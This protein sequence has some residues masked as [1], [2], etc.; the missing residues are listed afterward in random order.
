M[1]KVKCFSIAMLLF[2]LISACSAPQLSTPPLPLPTSTS[3]PTETA[4]PRPTYTNTPVPTPTMIPTNTP[5]GQI[6]RDDFSIGIQ[7]DWIWQNENPVRWSIT[8]E[9]WL[10]ILGEDASLLVDDFQNNLLCRNAPGGDYQISV[11]LFA[12]PIEDF[13]QATLYLYQDGD[14][15]I[16]INRGYCSICPTGGNGVFMEYKLAGA[17]GVYRVRTQANDIFL[18]LVVKGQTIIG[19]YAFETEEWQ[20]FGKVGNYLED[21]IICLGVSNVDSLGKNVDLV[22]R[23]D[24][25]DISLP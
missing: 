23:F 8:P 20:H 1:K 11:H 6:F 15:Y 4:T 17:V 24:Y 5:I 2:I 22:G 12:D 10:Q 7:T 13:Q 14:N 25:I 19:Y 16:A 9:G 18:R 3:A 21:A